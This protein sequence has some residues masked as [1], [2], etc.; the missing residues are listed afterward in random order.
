MSHVSPDD[1]TVRVAALLHDI[2]HLPFSH[3]L[4]GLAGLDHHRLGDQRIA[5]LAPILRRH[6]IDCELVADLANG[7]KPSVL[8]GATRAMRLDHLESF[9]R[10]GRSHGRTQEPPPRTFSRLGLTDGAVDTDRE[11]ADYLLDLVIGEALSQT[12]PP[13]LVATAVLRHLAG[14]LLNEAVSRAVLR[15]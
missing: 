13:N 10:S 4:E 14:R 12:S 1:Q 8:H 15:S 3:T 9:V 6:G 11:T 7:T 5:D 2:G